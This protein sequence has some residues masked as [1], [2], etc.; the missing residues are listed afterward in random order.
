MQLLDLQAV[1]RDYEQVWPDG[2]REVYPH[3]VEYRAVAPDS[4]HRVRIGFG[5]RAVY[6]QDRKRVVVWI[7]DHPH[8]EFLG[9]DDFDLSGD[10]LS[11][12]K[13]PGQRGERICRYG[14]EAI[15]ERYSG[16]PVVGLST[17]VSGPNLRQAWAIVANIADHRTLCALG[18]LRRLERER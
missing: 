15:P 18:A 1:G 4:E 8:A 10:L 5:R 13:I 2:T 6:G 16:L 11:E 12:I 17:R 3:W 14:E 7:D 9:A